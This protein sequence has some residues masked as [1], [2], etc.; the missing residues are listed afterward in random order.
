MIGLFQLNNNIPLFKVH[1]RDF[2]IQLKDFGTD[3][4][5]KELYSE[6]ESRQKEQATAAELQRTLEVPG[7]IYAGP[8]AHLPVPNSSADENY[9]AVSVDESDD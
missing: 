3:D 4:N 7:L 5:I 2:L 8:S 9:Q 1:L 6:E